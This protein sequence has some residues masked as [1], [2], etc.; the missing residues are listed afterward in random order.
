MS[1]Q[2]QP[3]DRPIPEDANFVVFLDSKRRMACFAPNTELLCW[4]KSLWHALR[5]HFG[6]IRPEPTHYL[7]LPTIPS[8][9]EERVSATP[10]AQQTD[11]PA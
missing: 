8:P 9:D 1:E 11:Q 5:L 4:R 2:W 3:I 7:V 10:S 6:L